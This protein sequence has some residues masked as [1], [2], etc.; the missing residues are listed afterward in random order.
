MPRGLLRAWGGSRVGRAVVSFLADA[1]ADHRIVGVA[2]AD[3][4]G[5][6]SRLGVGSTRAQGPGLADP[7]EALRELEAR[8]SAVLDIARGGPGLPKRVHEAATPAIR[9]RPRWGFLLLGLGMIAAGLGAWGVAATRV[10]L[11]YDE[12]F[13]AIPSEILPFLAH[14]RMTLAGTMLSIGILYTALALGAPGAPWVRRAIGISAT[15][16]FA[17]FFLFLA[18]GYFDPLHAAISAALFPLFLW[19]IAR[20]GGG[21]AHARAAPDLAN[22]RAWHRAQWGTLGFVALGFGLVVGGLT[23][24]AVGSTR[25]FVAS[26]LAFLGPIPIE[27]RLAALVAHDRAGFGGALVS[28]GVLVALAAMWGIR[29]GAAWLWWSFLAAGVVGFGSTIGVHLF[30][31]YTDAL[32]LAPVILAAAIFVASLAALHGYMRP[33]LRHS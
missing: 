24:A 22:D 12:A 33:A 28:N 7:G 11:P 17:N 9:A 15:L 1:P 27:D 20:P 29:R 8:G 4:A 5:I 26:D 18:Y 30:V 31:G 32:H 23:I 19:G 14:D 21:S 2:S 13:V 16:G 25:V 10:V 3:A 6:V